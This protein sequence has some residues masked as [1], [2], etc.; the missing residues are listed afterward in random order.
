MRFIKFDIPSISGSSEVLYL[1]N[2]ATALISLRNFVRAAYRISVRPLSA[3]IKFFE[4]LCEHFSAEILG[5]C[6]SGLLLRWLRSSGLTE[7]AVALGGLDT[8][9]DDRCFARRAS[10]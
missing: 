6:R 7:N 9:Q 2:L 4:E 10:R 5:Y 3:K 1:K 8:S